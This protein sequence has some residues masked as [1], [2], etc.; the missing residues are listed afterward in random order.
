MAG[1]ILFRASFSHSGAHLHLHVVAVSSPT[2]RTVPSDA[3]SSGVLGRPPRLLDRRWLETTAPAGSLLLGQ[4][5]KGYRPTRQKKPGRIYS[6][7][8]PVP[9][10]SKKRPFGQLVNPP[11][12]RRGQTRGSINTI[13]LL[14]RPGI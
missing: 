14:E 8:P 5:A 7:V 9:F 3:G 6:T 12:G 13:V 1:V 4:R 11:S 2:G 10:L